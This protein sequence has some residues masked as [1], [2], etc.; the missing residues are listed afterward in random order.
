MRRYRLGA[1]LASTRIDYTKQKK[2][3]KEQGE[4][5]HSDRTK[6]NAAAEHH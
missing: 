3:R 6:K 4:A 2:R 5:E 1:K